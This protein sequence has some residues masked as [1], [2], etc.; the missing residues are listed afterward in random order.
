GEANFNA[1]QGTYNGG[2][3]VGSVFEFSQANYVVAERGGSA[4]ITV[5]RTGDTTAAAAVDYATDDGSVASVAVPC[6]LV[7]GLALERCDYTG[8]TGPLRFAANETERS[9]VVLVNDDSYVEGP[10]NISVK[11]SNPSSGASLGLGAPAI[12]QIID[13]PTESFGNPIDDEEMFV[14]QHYHD[15]LNREPDPDGLTF[16]TKNLTACESNLACAERKRVDP[17]AAFFLSIE[18]QETGY[19]VERFYKVAYGDAT[20]SSTFGG[21]HQLSVPS[22]RWREFLRDTQEIGRDVVVR[23]GEWQQQLEDHKQAFARDFISRQRFMNAYPAS[24]SAEQFV[25][26]L[27]ANAGN[28]LSKGDMVQLEAVF[29]GPNA[30]SA[31]ATQRAQVLRSVAEDHT[32]EKREFNRAFVLMQYFGYLRRNP[33][34]A[35]DTD[36]TGYDFWLRKLEQFEGNYVNAEM[37]KAF[38]SSIEYRQRF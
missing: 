14:R 22:I 24:L 33:D 2:Q 6:S 21:P 3:A 4:T 17:S 15:L 19:L 23:Q 35:Q 32:L 12:L 1:S 5:K 9:F 36:Y 13:D 38:I 30:S 18:F 7:T 11:L 28:V 8:S 31:D 26:Q 37:V 27:N 25:N 29:G 10:E 16:W 34:D 20:G